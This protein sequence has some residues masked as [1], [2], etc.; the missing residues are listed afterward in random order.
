[1]GQIRV[2]KRL[3]ILPEPVPRNEPINDKPVVSR[4]GPGKGRSNK[5]GATVGYTPGLH[6][7]HPLKLLPM[8]RIP[9]F[10]ANHWMLAT[11]FVVLA[12]ALVIIESR[13][14]G[15]SLGP[16][17]VGGLVNREHAV[18]LDVRVDSDFRGGH[19][20]G[21][22]NIPLAQLASRLGELEKYKGKPLIMVCHVGHSAGDAAK[23][24]IK[25]GHAPVYC[26]AGGINAWRGENLPV[27]KA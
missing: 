27:V 2:G 20:A 10:L 25:A 18:L 8:D 6:F 19:I 13:R 3:R 12:I 21:S 4:G 16:A 9:E 15:K 14:G 5:D 1:M 26:L 7:L 11:T 17:L 24:L 23:Q 22:V